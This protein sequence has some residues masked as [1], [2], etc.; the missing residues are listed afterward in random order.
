MLFESGISFFEGPLS[1]IGG[2]KKG[3]GRKERKKEG[4]R[5]GGRKRVYFGSKS[6]ITVCHGRGGSAAGA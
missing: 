2:G 5:E 3:E 4:R 1:L 6:D